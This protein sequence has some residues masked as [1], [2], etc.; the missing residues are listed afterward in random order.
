MIHGWGLLEQGTQAEKEPARK[1]DR[2]SI[3]KQLLPVFLI[4]SRNAFP[5]ISKGQNSRLF[6]LGRYHTPF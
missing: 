2:L 3:L 1:M 5:A 4:P 6:P